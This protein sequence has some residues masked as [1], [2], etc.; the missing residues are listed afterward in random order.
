MNVQNIINAVF[1][2]GNPFLARLFPFWQSGL[3]KL[4]PYGYSANWQPMTTSGVGVQPTTAPTI[5][6]S[7]DFILEQMNFVA[8]AT[9][10]SQAIITNPSMLLSIQ[11][12][13]GT[14]VFA[15]TDRPVALWTGNTQSGAKNYLLPFPRRIFG[16]NVLLCKLTDN[17]G[18][19]SNCWLGLDGIRVEYTGTN[20][21]TVF[22]NSGY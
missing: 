20:R 17:G 22:P 11:E 16:N 3:V 15:D 5:D 14:T 4:L 8:N 1:S 7:T 13:S 18:T 19:P 6:P 12:K 9:T 21:E 2:S 10:G